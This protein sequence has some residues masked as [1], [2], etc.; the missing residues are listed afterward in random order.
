[1][2]Y[3]I[4][5]AQLVV[6][7]HLNQLPDVLLATRRVPLQPPDQIQTGGRNR[8]VAQFRPDIAQCAVL[9]VG[10]HVLEIGVN[11]LGNRV[12]QANLVG[13]AFRS[14]TG[15]QTTAFPETPLPEQVVAFDRE[16]AGSP[17]AFDG[18]LRQYHR[19]RQR[20]GAVQNRIEIGRGSGL[21]LHFVVPP[22]LAHQLRLPGEVIMPLAGFVTH[23]F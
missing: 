23:P 10:V 17:G 8:Q 3:L 1:M 15:H 21:G 4:K 13:F 2:R 19:G 20:I 12:E 18:G 16:A 11:G 22:Q 14:A 6:L 5:A 7:D 9:R